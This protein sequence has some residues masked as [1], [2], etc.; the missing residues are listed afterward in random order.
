MSWEFDTS[1]SYS[2]IKSSIESTYSK[3]GIT[4]ADVGTLDLSK[5]PE[6]GV[7]GDDENTA[8]PWG[9]VFVVMFSLLLC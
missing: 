1:A 9:I 5:N 7:C 8:T 2:D 4:C 3:L 6:Y